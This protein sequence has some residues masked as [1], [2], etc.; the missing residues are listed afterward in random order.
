MMRRLIV[1]ALLWVP[2]AAFAEGLAG[3]LSCMQAN[4]PP[5]VRV[6]DIT[7]TA[8]DRDGGTRSIEGRL[9]VTSTKDSDGQTLIRSVLKISSPDSFA[10]AAYLIRETADQTDPGMYVYLPSVRR[11]RRVTGSFADGALLGTDFSYQD[12]KQLQYAFSGS[13]ISL[14]GEDRIEGHRVLQLALTPKVA[15][16]S[17]Y[18]AV[19]M[20]IDAQ[21]CVPLKAQFLTGDKLV[22]EL[23]VP[24]TGLRQSGKSWY[25]SELRMKDLVAG[26]QSVLTVAELR[27]Q[28]QISPDVFNVERFYLPGGL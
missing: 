3:V 5:A 9:A 7:L 21:T 14:E 22:K 26:T 20:W 23:T 15:K 16:D 2:V 18:S 25:A 8:T 27:A 10:G 13:N 11:V 6:Q 1:G 28:T 4:V 12:F 19:K 17:R 24:A